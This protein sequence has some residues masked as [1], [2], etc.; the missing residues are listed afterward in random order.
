[1]WTDRRTDRHDETKIVF[2]NFVYP[3]KNVTLS[4]HHTE[5][6]NIKGLRDDLHRDY[7]TTKKKLICRPQAV[8]VFSLGTIQFVLLDG[9]FNKH[10]RRWHKGD[11]ERSALIWNQTQINRRAANHTTDGGESTLACV[12]TQW[13]YKALF[14]FRRRA[15]RKRTLTFTNKYQHKPLNS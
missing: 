6:I 9:R 1:M 3:P 7:N 4:K 8:A 11:E 5:S 2:Q 15:W 10:S 13:S 14:T 12:K